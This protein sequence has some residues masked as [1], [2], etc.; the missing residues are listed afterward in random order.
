[1][2]TVVLPQKR[3]R[4]TAPERYPPRLVLVRGLQHFL[5]LIPWKYVAILAGEMQA[6]T[7]SPTYTPCCNFS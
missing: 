1:M 7:P 4:H 5:L 3:D 2:E 6:Q